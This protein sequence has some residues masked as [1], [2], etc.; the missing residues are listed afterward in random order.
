MLYCSEKS[1]GL[2][3]SITLYTGEQSADNVSE[4]GGFSEPCNISIVLSCHCYGASIEYQHAVA[5]IS[6]TQLLLSWAFQHNLQY[7]FIF[8]SNQPIILMQIN[9][10]EIQGAY[11]I[12]VTTT[13]LALLISSRHAELGNVTVQGHLIKVCFYCHPTMHEQHLWIELNPYNVKFVDCCG[14][15][16][17]FKSQRSSRS[18]DFGATSYKGT[19]I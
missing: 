17:P 14:Y 6:S 13:A 2:R 19:P 16:H 1:I 4:F 9:S 10:G 12:K 15:N 18:V 11:Q 8:R 5:N 7:S 3:K